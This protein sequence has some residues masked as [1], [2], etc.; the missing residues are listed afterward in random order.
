MT[1]SEDRLQTG[2]GCGINGISIAIGEEK[3]SSRFK[4]VHACSWAC[5]EGRKSFP[6][7][8]VKGTNKVEG[9]EGL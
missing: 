4:E 1:E 5:R 7:F 6:L 9:K 2:A 8:V 3:S